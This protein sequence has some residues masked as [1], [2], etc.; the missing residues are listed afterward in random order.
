M[1]TTEQD[2]IHHLQRQ[3]IRAGYTLQGNP[4]PGYPGIV[5]HSDSSIVYANAYVCESL[6]YSEEE[7]QGFNAWLLF[8]PESG[9]ALMEHVSTRSEEPYQ[10]MARHKNGTTFAVTLKG[11]NFTLEGEA[12]RSVLFKKVGLD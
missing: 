1:H 6:G 12:L 4:S 7:M 5:I 11:H 8:T 3:L 9:P 2:R 10:A